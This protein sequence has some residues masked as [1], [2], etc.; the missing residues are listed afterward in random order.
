MKGESIKKSIRRELKE[1]LPVEFIDELRELCIPY[2]VQITIA[3]KA[4][5]SDR[6]MVDVVSSGKATKTTYKKIMKA[7]TALKK[8]S[9]QAAA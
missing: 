8:E 3:R 5:I 7:I 1:D 2:G 9:A 4:K 6:S